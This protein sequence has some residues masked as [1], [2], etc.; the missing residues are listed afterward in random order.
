M[1][2]TKG[3]GSQ[4]ELVGVAAGNGKDQ[5]RAGGEFEEF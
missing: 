5:R 3:A 1:D 4:Q 2:A